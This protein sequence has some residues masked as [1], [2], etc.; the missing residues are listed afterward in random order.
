MHPGP[1]PATPSG[2]GVLLIDLENMVGHKARPSILMARVDA[3][4]QHAGPGLPVVAACAE[5]RISPQGKQILSDRGARLLVVGGDKNAADRALLEEA[6]RLAANGCRRFVVASADRAF[7]RL[8]ELGELEVMLWE[9]PEPRR[10]NA[11]TR[12]AT[13]VHWVPL[14][15]GRPKTPSVE[16]ET[17]NLRRAGSLVAAGALFG[18]GAVL[19]G[20]V[21]RRI[22]RAK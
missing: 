11:Y 16:P 1:L 21:A 3:L 22:L 12:R 18:F 2:P 8:A 4:V 9:A 17:E 14:P 13:Q 19:G 5:N 7:G 20:T 10:L 6:K 15:P